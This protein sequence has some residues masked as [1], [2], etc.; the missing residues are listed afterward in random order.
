MTLACAPSP[1]ACLPSAAQLPM[2]AR[3]PVEKETAPASP[4]V[5]L[6][7]LALLSELLARM[8]SDPD[9]DAEAN[10]YAQRALAQ[11]RAER[12]AALRSVSELAA[13]SS[14]ATKEEPE[15]VAQAMARCV[16]DS[17][18]LRQHLTRERAVLSGSSKR[19]RLPSRACRQR[20]ALL[21]CAFV[22]RVR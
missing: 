8:A 11:A 19:S 15:G 5:E 17:R 22:A 18:G 9:A 20:C 16:N 1:V 2:P 4:G 14:A 12:D 7:P 10:A 3:A 21:L 6:D 13:G